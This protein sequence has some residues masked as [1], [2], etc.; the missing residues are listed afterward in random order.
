MTLDDTV[1]RDHPPRP[2]RQHRE[3]DHGPSE[4]SPQGS[5]P[6]QD[7]PEADRFGAAAPL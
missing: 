5:R 3:N 6:R 2:P 7:H 4:G 1:R